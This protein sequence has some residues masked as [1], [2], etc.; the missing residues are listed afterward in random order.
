MRGLLIAALALLSGCVSIVEVRSDG[1]AP[2]ISL[3][4]GS[5]TVKAAPRTALT[6]SQKTVGL[7]A[8]CGAY[9]VGYVSAR[10][11]TIPADTCGVAI[12]QN[13]VPEPLSRW[14]WLFDQTA[15]AC[16]KGTIP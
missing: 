11:V 16:L 10:C 3:H 5:I 9:G 14:S 2:K 4:L 7:F 12:I 1:V 13:S 8:S 6:V 15:A